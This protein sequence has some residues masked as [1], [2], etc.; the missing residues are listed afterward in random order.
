MKGSTTGS[1][2]VGGADSVGREGWEDTAEG[3]SSG[4]SSNSGTGGVVGSGIVVG[5]GV[6]IDWPPVWGMGN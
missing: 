4:V 1:G 2:G 3:I 5:T 6:G